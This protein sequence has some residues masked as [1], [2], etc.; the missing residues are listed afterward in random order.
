[1]RIKQSPEKIL[2]MT[3]TANKPNRKT[4]QFSEFQQKD[5]NSEKC[6]YFHVIQRNIHLK[7]GTERNRTSNS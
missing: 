2:G 5:V 4:T 1:M 6:M 7:N 3:E